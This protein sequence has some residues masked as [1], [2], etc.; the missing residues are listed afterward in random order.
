[1]WERI[2]NDNNS[3]ILKDVNKIKFNL[4]ELLRTSLKW[5]NEGYENNIK[6]MYV[7]LFYIND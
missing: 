1:M 5:I 3:L 7:Y 6:L 2:I 4:E